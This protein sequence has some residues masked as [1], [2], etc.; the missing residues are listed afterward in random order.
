MK[1]KVGL[2]DSDATYLKRMTIAFTSRFPD[3]VE[4]YSF[5]KPDIAIEEAN[6]RNLDVFL[7]STEYQIDTSKL[8]P[9]CGFAYLVD[10]QDVDRIDDIMTV[11]KYQK[12]ELIY[13][14]ILSIYSE[15]ANNIS[16]TLLSEKGHTKITYF[17]SVSGGCGTTT[18]A[19]ATAKRLAKYGRKVLYLNLEDIPSTDVFFQGEGEETM[20]DII[21]ALKSKKMNLGL[22]IESCLRHDEHGVNFFAAS[23][24]ALDVCELSNEN[25]ISLIKEIQLS[26]NFDNVIIDGK[27]SLGKEKYMILDDCADCVFVCDGSQTSIAKF[28]NAYKCMEIMDNQYGG[29]VVDKISI[30]YNRFS[31]NVKV[32][33][34]IENENIRTIG[35]IG[36]IEGAETKELVEQIMEKTFL[37]QL[38]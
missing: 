36:R 20:S 26:D 1:I 8:P 16:K 25:I 2:L 15:K 11:S 24:I 30:I 3:K 4:V 5:T 29:N 17:T 19:S 37:D 7:F 27:F 33:N 32:A 28:N 12:A 18:V 21:Y 9:K 6:D 22:K 34:T 31:S 38:M 35:G 13:K 23:R 14:K 10:A